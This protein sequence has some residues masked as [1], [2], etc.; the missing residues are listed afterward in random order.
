MEWKLL[1][2]ENVFKYM[3]QL[4]IQCTCAVNVQMIASSKFSIAHVYIIGAL[5]SS[6]YVHVLTV[7]VSVLI[8]LMI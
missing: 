2:R 4:N 3:Y 1:A 8:N 7:H 5:N 6:F